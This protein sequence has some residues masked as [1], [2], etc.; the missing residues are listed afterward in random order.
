MESAV[1]LVFIV[2]VCLI[3]MFI[4]LFPSCEQLLPGQKIC[5]GKGDDF[6]K[7]AS[8]GIFFFAILVAVFVIGGTIILAALR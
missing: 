8:S 3:I 4:I 6:M 5:E 2:F 1:Y 7:L